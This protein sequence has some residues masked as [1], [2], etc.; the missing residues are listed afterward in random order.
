MIDF[1]SIEERSDGMK[2]Y[3]LKYENEIIELAV[4]KW[5]LMDNYK[6]ETNN[7]KD[8]LVIVEGIFTEKE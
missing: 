2:I 5:Q 3:A 7:L 1:I 6:F 4:N 8:K